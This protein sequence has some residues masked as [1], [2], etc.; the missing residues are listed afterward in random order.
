MTDR[1]SRN[2]AEERVI[3]PYHVLWPGY[4]NQKVRLWELDANA[5]HYENRNYATA[6]LHPEAPIINVADI[7]RFAQELEMTDELRKEFN[8]N[9]WLISC[10]Y[11]TPIQRSISGMDNASV[12]SLLTDIARKAEELDALLSRLPPEVE[13]ALHFIR[14]VEPEAYK[15]EGESITTTHYELHDLAVVAKTMSE[16][17]VAQDGRPSEHI[18]N[19]MIELLLV[20]LHKADAYDLRI[21]DGNKELGP[22]LAGKA[23]EFLARLL[24]HLAPDQPIEYWVPKIKPVR[25]KVNRQMQAEKH[26]AKNPA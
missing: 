18:R 3:F 14:K 26:K 17:I 10:F 20:E 13:A 12:Q 23:G 8:R 1:K 24:R 19:S 16:D 6:I 4:G 25:T 22:H 7:E 2:S 9:A 11:L 5:Q 15:P 21:S